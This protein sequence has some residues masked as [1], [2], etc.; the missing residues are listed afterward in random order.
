M[1]GKLSKNLLN[2]FW[3]KLSKTWVE[4]DDE[5]WLGV[6]LVGFHDPVI[7]YVTRWLSND[8]HWNWDFKKNVFSTFYL[9]SRLPLIIIKDQ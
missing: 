7:F 8:Q 4:H 3:V 5:D 9:I 2:I 1:L 6:V